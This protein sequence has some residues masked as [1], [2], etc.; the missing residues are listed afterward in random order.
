M[1]SPLDSAR[2]MLA[3]AKHHLTELER[4]IGVYLDTDPVVA[5]ENAE[6]NDVSDGLKA[7]KNGF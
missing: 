6:A 4:E 5:E 1:V 7:H 2:Y 3:R